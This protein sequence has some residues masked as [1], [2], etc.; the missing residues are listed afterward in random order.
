M[1]KVEKLSR[2]RGLI[3]TWKRKRPVALFCAVKWTNSL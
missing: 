3:F 1:I 2:P